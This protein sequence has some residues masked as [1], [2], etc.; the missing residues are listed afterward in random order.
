M[1]L[2]HGLRSVELKFNGDINTKGK[3]DLGETGVPANI[4]VKEETV[5]TGLDP[6]WMS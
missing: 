5:S 6:E 3:Y 1:F 4:W 2:R